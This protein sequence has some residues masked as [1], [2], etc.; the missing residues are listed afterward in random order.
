MFGVA[1]IVSYNSKQT[2][3]VEFY[4]LVCINKYVVFPHFLT[5]SMFFVSICQLFDIYCIHGRY[6]KN[7]V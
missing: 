6:S 4:M 1:M 7:L 2:G 3:L 5:C